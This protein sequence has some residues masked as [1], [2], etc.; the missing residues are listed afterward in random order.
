MEGRVSDDLAVDAPG[1]DWL[2]RHRNPDGRL[3]VARVLEDRR[4]PVRLDGREQVARGG[5]V[6]WFAGVFRTLWPNCYTA[7]TSVSA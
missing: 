6:E 3:D 2:T 4:N 7:E 1:I 5:G